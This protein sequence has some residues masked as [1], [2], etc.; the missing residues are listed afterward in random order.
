MLDIARNSS[1]PTLMSVTCSPGP[2]GTIENVINAGT[3]ASPARCVEH[4]VRACRDELLLEEQL[5][6]V[7]HG[8]SRPNGPTRLGPKRPCMR[9][10][11]LRSA[12]TR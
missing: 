3:I 1:R 6:D 11:I 12:H 7:R 5:D 9:P 10:Q 4:L 8:W 2:N